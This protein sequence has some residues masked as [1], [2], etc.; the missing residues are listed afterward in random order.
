MVPAAVSFQRA[1][2]SSIIVLA[3]ATIVAAI[4]LVPRHAR[5]ELEQFLTRSARSETP[6]GEG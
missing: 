3:I 2:T 5:T 6:K 1:K 4:W